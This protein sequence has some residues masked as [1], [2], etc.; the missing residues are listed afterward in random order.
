MVP[1]NFNEIGVGES[2]K[3]S[4]SLPW[5][6]KVK[7]QIQVIQ[8]KHKRWPIREHDDLSVEWCRL[9]DPIATLLQ[10]WTSNSP[11][12]ATRS[13]KFRDIRW[14]LPLTSEVTGV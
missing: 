6:R 10:L 9:H 11:E 7:G 4:N 5:P 14:L 8:V 2:F 3:I 13:A 1:V 12:K